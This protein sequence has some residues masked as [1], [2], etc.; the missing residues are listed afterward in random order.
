MQT[1]HPTLLV[2]PG[3]WDS[4]RLPR[5]DYDDR[6]DALWRDHAEAGGAIVYGNSRD[7]AA[8]AYLTHFTPKLEA[9]IALIPRHGEPQMLIGGGVNMLPAAKPLTFISTLAPLRDAAKTIADWARDLTTGGSLV[10][11]GGDAMPY[12]LRHALDHALDRALGGRSTENGDA[13]LHARMRRKSTNE[14]RILRAACA[15]LDAAVA[16]LRETACAGKSA[17]ECLLA[18]EHTALQRGAQDVR[19]LFSLD[20]GRTLRPFDTPIAQ[21]CDPLQA[22]LAVRHDGYWADAFVRAGTQDDTLGLKVREILQT[23]LTEVK[24]G[25]SWRKLHH[26][27]DT[28]RGTLALH[29]L[30]DQ[31]FGSSIGLSLDEPPRLGGDGQAL[32]EADVVYSLRSGLIDEAG[33]GAVV[34]ALALAAE[35]GPELL[36]PIGG[37][38]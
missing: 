16:T 30:A 12:E 29:P 19:S 11:L 35:H 10:L 22:Y 15:I 13:A 33:A 36:W 3:D 14:L 9:A 2:G 4:Q 32:L 17:T 37:L 24:P 27:A 7:H 20:G 38:S 31:I 1:M 18:A 23:M 26:L 25:V 8:L 28:G 21:R 5:K 34:S 6:L